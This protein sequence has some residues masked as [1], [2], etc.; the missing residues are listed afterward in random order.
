MLNFWELAEAVPKAPP[1]S[2]DD[3]SITWDGRRLDTKEKVLAFLAELD[4]ARASGVAL[5]RPLS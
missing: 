3:V 5:G 4:A 1:P 2:A